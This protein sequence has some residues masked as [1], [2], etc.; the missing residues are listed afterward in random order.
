MKITKIT[1]QKKNKS[2]YNVY[3]DCG[4]GEEF[5]FAIDEDVY[6]KFGIEKGM[7]LSAKEISEL[8]SEDEVRK[9]F[10]QAVNYLSYRMRSC[11]EIVEYLKKKEVPTSAIE[12]IMKRLQELKYIDDLEFAKMFIRSK[13]TTSQKGPKAL[14]QELKLKG[15]SEAII[16]KAILVYPQDQQIESATKLAKKKAKQ[17][18]K[19]SEIAAKQKIG[20]LLKQKGFSWTIIEQ[21]IEKASLQKDEQE[22]REALDIQAQKAHRKYRKFSGWE[23]KQ[24]MKQQLYRKG[25]SIELIDEWLN[26]TEISDQ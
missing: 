12:A 16:E 1:V 22:E 4:H 20:Q 19:L 7:E 26:E 5:G 6:I 21:A 10:N 8:Q 25:F 9:G 24:K 18:Q 15:V 3:V 23:Y 11:Q 14:E 17:N 2:R 13:V